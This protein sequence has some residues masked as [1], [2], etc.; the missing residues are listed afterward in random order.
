M[1]TKLSTRR[2]FMRRRALLRQ[3]LRRVLNSITSLRLD[4]IGRGKSEH[5]P[6]RSAGNGKPLTTAALHLLRRRCRVGKP[7]HSICFECSAEHY[8]IVLW[9]PQRLNSQSSQVP[10]LKDRLA[11]EAIGEKLRS[12]ILF[13]AMVT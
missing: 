2:S 5:L 3:R 9:V 12:K 1:E 6:A 11:V 8:S 4:G 13:S 7:E 10:S